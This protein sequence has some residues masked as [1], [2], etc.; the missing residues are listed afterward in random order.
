MLRPMSTSDLEPGDPV[1][2]AILA[3]GQGSTFSAL[4]EVG[5]RAAT[6]FEVVLLITSRADSPAM[7]LAD[8]LKVQQI[9]LDDRQLGTEECDLA[10]HESLLTRQIDLIVLA[11]YVRKVG[12]RVLRTFAGRVF[13]THPAPLPRFGGKGMYGDNVHRAVL[14]SGVSESA[15]I[16]H[17]VDAEYDTGPVIAVA[18]VP[19]VPGDDIASLRARVQGAERELLVRTLREFAQARRLAS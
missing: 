7:Q 1:R 12:P 5:R 16:V 6:P 10:M 17:L 3:S 15:P 18:P 8:T 13:N 9:T 14:E 4:V 19:V 2:V 11:G